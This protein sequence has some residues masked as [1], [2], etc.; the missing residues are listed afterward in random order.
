VFACGDLAEAPETWQS[1]VGQSG[2]SVSL[3]PSPVEPPE[4]FSSNNFM[5]NIGLALKELLSEKEEA[6]FS[7]VNF[8]ALPEVYLP[9]RF[10]ILRVL[11]PVGIVIGIGLIIFAVILTQANRADIEALGSELAVAEG[12]VTQQQKEIAALNAQVGPV[13]ATASELNA[14]IITMERGRATIHEDLT[15]IVR[16]AGEKVTFGIADHSGSSVTLKEWW[17]SDED[18]IFSYARDLRN[19]GR[20][21]KVWISRIEESAGGFKFEFSLPK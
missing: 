7:L 20:F 21:S 10:S 18:D 6:N 19:G 1:V 16:L 3:L 4:G 17:A 15:Q 11:V 2:Y 5:V 12:R 13:E 9:E 8:N 14:R